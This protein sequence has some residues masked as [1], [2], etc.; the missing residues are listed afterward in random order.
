[1]N[2][3]KQSGRTKRMKPI[4]ALVCIK[5]QHIVLICHA[6]IQATRLKRTLN[7]YD[8]SELERELDIHYKEFA[9][10]LEPSI[11]FLQKK[12]VEYFPT[13]ETLSSAWRYKLNGGDTP[14]LLV[15]FEEIQRK[16]KNS[17][18]RLWMDYLQRKGFRRIHAEV[19]C[20]EIIPAIKKYY[21]NSTGIEI[22]VQ[23]GIESRPWMY[24]DELV[25]GGMLKQK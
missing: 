24:R 3:K 25:C 19:D 16:Y 23:Y 4:Y 22:G 7:R 14:T 18:I 8:A 15:L 20:I 10:L 9:Y 21:D 5:I 6:F 2:L 13:Q 1:M 11:C 12:P 17:V